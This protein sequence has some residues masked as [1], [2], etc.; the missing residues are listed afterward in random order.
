MRLVMIGQ[1]QKKRNDKEFD[2]CFLIQISFID[3]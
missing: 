1:R 2:L 3:A